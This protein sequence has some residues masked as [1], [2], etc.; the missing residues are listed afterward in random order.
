L[1]RA[2]AQVSLRFGVGTVNGT[3]DGHCW[4]VYRD[5]PLRERRDPR[6]VF[7]ETWAIPSFVPPARSPWLFLVAVT[8]ARR[9]V[10]DRCADRAV[11]TLK[12]L[13]RSAGNR[14]AH[15]N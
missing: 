4:I 2:G 12:L 3:I 6:A 15:V 10:L 5:E 11:L 9:H 13:R 7:S 8:R 14:R 1:R